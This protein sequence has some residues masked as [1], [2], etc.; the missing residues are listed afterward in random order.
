MGFVQN[1]DRHQEQA[2]LGLQVVTDVIFNIG[3]LKFNFTVLS[4][5][6]KGMFKLKFREEAQSVRE[7]VSEEQNKTMEVDFF[8]IV[9][10]I[11]AYIVVV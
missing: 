7:F 5:T 1:A 4:I 3:L 2:T 6:R 8:F 11:V 9:D 10:A